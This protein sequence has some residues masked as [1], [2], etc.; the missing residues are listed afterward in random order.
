M[1]TAASTHQNKISTVLEVRKP[2]L[3]HSLTLILKMRIKTS[4]LGRKSDN[5][6][7]AQITK[8]G[9][10]KIILPAGIQDYTTQEMITMSNKCSYKGQDRHSADRAV[11]Q[12]ERPMAKTTPDVSFEIFL[13]IIF[14]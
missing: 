12:A 2:L 5:M 11:L 4:R 13:T 10:I 14:I 9:D 1:I 7:E 8:T 3:D 6:A